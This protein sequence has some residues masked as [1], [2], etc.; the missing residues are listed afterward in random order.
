M[1]AATRVT[2]IFH[3]EGA[4]SDVWWPWTKSWRNAW[5]AGQPGTQADAADFNLAVTLVAPWEEYVIDL[6]PDFQVRT[7]DD[8]LKHVIPNTGAIEQQILSTF[9]ASAQ[10]NVKLDALTPAGNTPDGDDDDAPDASDD[11]DQK[12]PK[13]QKDHKDAA[14]DHHGKPKPGAGAAGA[15]HGPSKQPAANPPGQATGKDPMLEYAAATAFFQEVKLLNRYVADAALRRGY[16]AYVVRLQMSVVP[17]ARNFPLDVYSNISFFPRTEKEDKTKSAKCQSW[18]AEVIPLL[19]T[20][21]LENTIKSRSLDSLRNLALT[22]SFLHPAAGGSASIKDQREELERAL[23]GDLNSLLTVGRVSDNTLQVRLGA[24]RNVAGPHDY[25]ILPR[26]HNITILLMVPEGFADNSYPNTV[27]RIT[28]VSKTQLRHAVTGAQLTGQMHEDR[29]NNA[30]QLLPPKYE[31]A[32]VEKLLHSVF[33]NDVDAF[34]DALKQAELEKLRTHADLTERWRAL[35]KDNPVPIDATQ[36]KEH[37]Q[38]IAAHLT[39]DP[40]ADVATAFDNAEPLKA[41]QSLKA[42]MARPAYMEDLWCDIVESLG[43]SQFAAVRFELPPAAKLPDDEMVLAVDDGES[44][45]VRLQGGAGLNQN[46]VTATLFVKTKAG[47]ILPIVPH[48]KIPGTEIN[49]LAGGHG[50][51]ITFPSL[52]AWKL[53]QD[54]AF[55]PNSR[56]LSDGE[57]RLRYAQGRKWSIKKSKG[58]ENPYTTV[59]YLKVKPKKSAAV[60][61]GPVSLGSAGPQSP[62]GHD[63]QPQSGHGHRAPPPSKQDAEPSSGHKK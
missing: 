38:A 8:A 12:D 49:I 11:K 61:D 30:W 53:D 3:E 35:Q 6:S 16:R 42:V 56:R 21:N 13:G 41:D 28:A 39:M 58:D 27:A 18:H 33:A 50:M 32:D 17:F 52:A 44:M 54:L 25:T 37:L 63:A 20:D 26:T 4:M 55:H 31:R 23:G 34:E 2:D 14:A 5:G 45:V 48:A 46:G 51:T 59:Y 60:P 29:Q 10:A 15:E 36:R 19:V 62:S 22:L 7:G 57:L 40:D 1:I 9:G 24:V 43:K 47:E